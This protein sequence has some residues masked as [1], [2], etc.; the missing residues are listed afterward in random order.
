M[1]DPSPDR[2]DRW[3]SLIDP[4][5]LRTPTRAELREVDLTIGELMDAALQRIA[6]ARALIERQL[7]RRLRKLR[8]GGQLMRLGCTHF[9]DYVAERLGMGLRSAQEMGSYVELNITRLM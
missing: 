3:A 4:S 2:L 1:L 6:A 9:G 5:L 8:D 7:G